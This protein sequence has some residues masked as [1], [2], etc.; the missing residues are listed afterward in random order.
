MAVQIGVF[1]L[2]V[3]FVL[4]LLKIPIAVSLPLLQ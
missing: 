1:L 4:L 2:I 3:F